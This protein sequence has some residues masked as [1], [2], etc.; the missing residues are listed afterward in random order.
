MK[1]RIRPSHSDWDNLNGLFLGNKKIITEN[2]KFPFSLFVLG[3]GLI[4]LVFIL[5]I[6][7]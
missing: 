5:G 3:I 1:F 6:Y 4:V 2:N 7:Y